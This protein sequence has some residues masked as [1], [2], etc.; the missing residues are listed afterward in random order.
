MYTSLKKVLNES[1][2]TERGS[3]R[4]HVRAICNGTILFMMNCSEDNKL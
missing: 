3:E 4:G 1:Y 2:E